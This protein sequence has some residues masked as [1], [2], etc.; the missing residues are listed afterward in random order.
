MLPRNFSGETQSQ[1]ATRNREAGVLA[2]VHSLIGRM[3]AFSDRPQKVLA[4]RPHIPDRGKKAR[5]G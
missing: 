4:A 1:V 5:Q 2:G 3:G